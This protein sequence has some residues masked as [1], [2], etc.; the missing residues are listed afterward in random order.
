MLHSMLAT[1]FIEFLDERLP[2]CSRSEQNQALDDLEDVVNI[3]HDYLVSKIKDR[4]H[5]ATN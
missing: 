5:D 1:K 2:L 4:S 3:L